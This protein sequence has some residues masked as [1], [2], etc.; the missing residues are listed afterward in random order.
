MLAP[1][2]GS[3]SG[4]VDGTF[5]VPGYENWTAANKITEGIT[6][7]AANIYFQPVQVFMILCVL[8]FIAAIVMQGKS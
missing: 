8:L 7:T 1:G 3:R 2:H 5:S 4:S 6:A